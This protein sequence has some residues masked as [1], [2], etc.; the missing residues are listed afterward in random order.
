MCDNM[1]LKITLMKDFGNEANMR[2]SRDA[3]RQKAEQAGYEF[4]WHLDG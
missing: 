1:R 3:V 2:A 4:D